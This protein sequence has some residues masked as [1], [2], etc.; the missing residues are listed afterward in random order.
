MPITIGDLNASSGDV[1]INEAGRDVTQTIQKTLDIEHL[2][3]IFEEKQLLSEHG[4]KIDALETALKN[5]NVDSAS[6]LIQFLMKVG[7]AAAS[8][9]IVSC[10][11]K[12]V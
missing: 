6:K 11:M 5:K 3:S 1:N 9:W 2:R 7:E 8:K 4:E 10:L 12:L